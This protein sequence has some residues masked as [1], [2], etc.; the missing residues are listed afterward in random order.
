MEKYRRVAKPRPEP[1]EIQENEIRVTTQG[2]MRNYIT[3]ATNLFTD[4]NANEIV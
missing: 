1:S 2:K 4:K 3:Y